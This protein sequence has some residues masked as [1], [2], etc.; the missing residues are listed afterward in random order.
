MSSVTDGTKGIPMYIILFANNKDGRSG[1][2]PISYDCILS[3][4]AGGI[5]PPP[6]PAVLR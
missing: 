2:G 3:L 4:C 1:G 6:D 5:A